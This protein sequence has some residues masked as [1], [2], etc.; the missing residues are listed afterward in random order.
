MNSQT[1]YLFCRGE[2]LIAAIK[3]MDNDTINRS[4]REKL[5]NLINKGKF[6][7]MMDRVNNFTKEYPNAPLVDAEFLLL[8]LILCTYVASFQFSSLNHK[9]RTA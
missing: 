9:V 4:G 6:T 5:F 2:R 7:E 8:C 3:S 1:C